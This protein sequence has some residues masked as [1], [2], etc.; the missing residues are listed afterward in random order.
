MKSKSAQ[1]LLIITISVYILVTSAYGQ[2]YCLAAADFISHNPKLENFDQEYLS[3]SD[4]GELKASGSGGLF[5]GSQ[6]STYL[7]ELLSHIFSLLSS[8]DQKTLILRC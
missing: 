7:I 4:Q 5:K 3:A 1:I 2:Y 6:L 8:F